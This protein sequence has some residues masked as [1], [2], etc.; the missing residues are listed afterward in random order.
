MGTLEN[1]FKMSRFFYFKIVSRYLS[2]MYLLYGDNDK[3]QN[4]GLL[5]IIMPRVKCPP[6]FPN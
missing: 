5:C 3:Y 4:R 1:K 6:P 2:Y